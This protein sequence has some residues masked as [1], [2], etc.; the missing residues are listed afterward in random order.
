MPDLTMCCNHECPAADSCWRYG[1][2]PSDRNQYYQKFIPDQ[3]NDEGFE[4]V[5]FIEY[6]GHLSFEEEYDE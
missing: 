3:D 5:F 1:C 6:P 4:C 2:P